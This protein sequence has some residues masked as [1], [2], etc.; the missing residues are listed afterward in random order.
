L[1]HR[2]QQ[3]DCAAVEHHEV[4][5]SASANAKAM[6]HHLRHGLPVSEGQRTGLDGQ[7]LLAVQANF[8]IRLQQQRE[9]RSTGTSQYGSKQLPYVQSIL[10]ASFRAWPVV[11]AHAFCSTYLHHHNADSALLKSKNMVRHR[12]RASYSWHRNSHVS[13]EAKS[14]RESSMP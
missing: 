11:T 2:A 1:R 12:A 7:H 14:C 4:A 13:V 10:L 5:C 9:Y 8:A 3:R 6:L